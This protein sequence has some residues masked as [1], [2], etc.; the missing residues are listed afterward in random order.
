[1]GAMNNA[2]IED[3]PWRI[4]TLG[5]QTRQRVADAG[6]WPYEHIL[7]TE[8]ATGFAFLAEELALSGVRFDRTRELLELGSGAVIGFLA[9]AADHAHAGGGHP[10]C[11]GAQEYDISV[12]C[13][14]ISTTTCPIAESQCTSVA[15]CGSPSTWV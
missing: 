11:P 6:D 12:G 15:Q 13:T 10:R 9:L 2:T 5:L 3:R 14:T 1:M 8:E 7:S 4:P